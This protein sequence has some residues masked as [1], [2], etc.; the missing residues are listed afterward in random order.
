MV[1]RI[2]RK[3]ELCRKCPKFQNGK[4]FLYV[5]QYYLCQKTGK[6]S[7]PVDWNDLDV[8]SNCILYTEHFLEDCN[9]QKA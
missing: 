3:I 4:D 1:A 5:Q 7:L 8:P 2:K 9:E 6:M